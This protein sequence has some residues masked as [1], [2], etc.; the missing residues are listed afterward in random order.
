MCMQGYVSIHDL[1]SMAE[2]N[3]N[4]KGDIIKLWVESAELGEFKI[5]G[6][7]YPDV[8]EMIKNT[9]YDNIY[10]IKE[11]IFQEANHIFKDGVTQTEVYM[12]L[13]MSFTSF[14]K[15]NF[16]I[17]IIKDLT[18]YYELNDEYMLSL[19]A[20]D[21]YNATMDGINMAL[22]LFDENK[23]ILDRMIED[24]EDADYIT[25][26]CKIQLQAGVDVVDKDN[27][28]IH[29]YPLVE[30]VLMMHKKDRCI[31]MIDLIEDYHIV[32]FCVTVLDEL[33]ECCSE[34]PEEVRFLTTVDLD[35]EDVGEAFD[36]FMAKVHE[37]YSNPT[38]Y[39]TVEE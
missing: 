22:S 2:L 13:V 18:I 28:L 39:P 20:I 31:A 17:S 14:H 27:A 9:S 24:G 25:T 12:L 34:L 7:K 29:V 30:P 23:R 3:D 38:N 35:T 8:V 1:A 10:D 16:G 5:R 26:E 37:Y 19:E 33:L 11:D 6:K 21:M 4:V 36:G 32:S 15:N